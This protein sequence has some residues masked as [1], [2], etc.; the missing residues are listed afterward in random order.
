MFLNVLW[1]L[2]FI[3]II[4]AY[5]V[6]DGFDLGVGIIHPFVPRDDREKRLSLNAIGPVWDGNETWLVMVLTMASRSSR[7]R[8]T[9]NK[10]PTP[11]SNPSN[12]T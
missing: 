12:T 7:R 5:V 6:L 2:L 1:Y 3:A 4:A 8:S 10:M 9:A 11:R